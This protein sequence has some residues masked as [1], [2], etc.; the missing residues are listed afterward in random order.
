[1]QALA[2]SLGRAVRPS[3]GHLHTRMMLTQPGNFEHL[4]LHFAPELQPYRPADLC[5]RWQTAWT[6]QCGRLMATT[7]RSYVSWPRAA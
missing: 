2:D 5:R 3:D 6:G 1:M 4:S 7:T